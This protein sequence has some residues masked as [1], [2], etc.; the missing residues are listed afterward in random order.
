[1]AA[2]N[3]LSFDL[4]GSHVAGAVCELETAKIF[5]VESA[6]ITNDIGP[7]EFFD[8]VEKLG[9]KVMAR[10]RIQAVAGIGMA[11]PNPFEMDTGVCRLEHKLPGLFGADFRAEVTRRF[12]MRRESVTF[13]NDA[14][15]FLLGE[16]TS[17]GSKSGRVVG[18]TLGTGVGSAF[19]VHGKIVTSEVGVPPGGEIWN[20]AWKA[21][22]VEDAVSTRAIQS[23][24]QSGDRRLTVREIAD[25]A[26]TD[27]AAKK[28][29]EDFGAELGAV[30]N[31]ICKDFAPRLIILGGA[32]SRSAALFLP[33]VKAALN[34]D[35]HI[36]ISTLF[37][38]A[39]LQGAAQAWAISQQRLREAAS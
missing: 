32:I 21:G 8:A 6:A 7:K 20:L 37:E 38:N 4:G 31:F 3:V 26:A 34:I 28:V 15:A 39:A 33:S 23:S 27:A 22:T 11:V 12:D 14:D 19:A 35:C 25:R 1:M 13:V 10:A 29:F 17:L 30:L 5:A 18:I 9:R 24:Y 16:L 36:E 2:R